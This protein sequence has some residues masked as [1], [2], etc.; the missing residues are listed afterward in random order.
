[1]ISYHCLKSAE[2]NGKKMGKKIVAAKRLPDGWCWYDYDDGSGSLRNLS[3]WRFYEYDLFNR[4]YLD[5]KTGHWE[6]WCS[7]LEFMDLDKYK[8]FAENS[9]LDLLK[10]E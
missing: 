3:G 7:R 1:M 6:N 8:D 4:Q 10:G 5:S 9:V 2:W